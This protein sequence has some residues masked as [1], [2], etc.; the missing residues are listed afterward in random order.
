MSMPRAVSLAIRTCDRLILWATMMACHAVVASMVCRRALATSA[1]RQLGTWGQ[2]IADVPFSVRSGTRY[3]AGTR[4]G[5]G[6][7]HRPGRLEGGEQ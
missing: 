4:P 1:S 6:P 2:W 7:R 3:R 5:R